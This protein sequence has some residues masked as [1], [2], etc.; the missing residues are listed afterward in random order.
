MRIVRHWSRLPGKV[1][2]T[3]PL[4]VCKARLEGALSNLIY[5]KLSLMMAGGVK[6]DDL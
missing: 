3:P 2:D 6:L 5:S 1:I 4:E